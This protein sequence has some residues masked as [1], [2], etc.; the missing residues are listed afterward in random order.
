MNVN[1]DITLT[2][3]QKEAYQAAHNKDIKFLKEK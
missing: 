2:Q 1:F 3:S